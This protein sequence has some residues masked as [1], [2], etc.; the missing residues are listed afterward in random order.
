[1]GM[2]AL[3]GD[4]YRK[5]YEESPRKRL[6]FS[7]CYDFFTKALAGFDKQTAYTVL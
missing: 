5:N 4:L 2:P 1:M 7:N 3:Y 6:F